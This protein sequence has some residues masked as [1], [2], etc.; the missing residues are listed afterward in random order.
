MNRTAT[1]TRHLASN[2]TAAEPNPTSLFL[3]FDHLTFFV[4]NAKQVAKYYSQAFGFEEVAYKGLETG[5][6]STASHVVKRDNIA[7]CFVSAYHPDSVELGQ[8]VGEHVLKHG[9]GV[10]DVALR[11]TDCRA[12]FYDAVG[13]GAKV[14]RE[15][16]EL[17]DEQGIVVLATIQTYGETVHT[18]VERSRYSGVFLPGY[19][20]VMPTTSLSTSTFPDIR[21][22]DHVVGNQGPHEM[23]AIADWYKDKLKFHRFWTVDDKMIHTEY[24]SLRSIVM[25]DD[26]FSVKMP[27]NEPAEGRKKSQI[28]EFVDFYHGQGVQHVA[29]N[30]PDCIE[31]VIRLKARGV[32]FLTVPSSYYGIFF[33]FLFL[34][35]NVIQGK[36]I[37]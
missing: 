15:P 32:E 23:Q 3:G 14:V 25:A 12:V 5:C 11:V 33:L 19:V 16:F 34:L 35:L 27:I 18:F 17:S 1:V 21:F 22:I 10:K 28:Q 31:T 8:N 24:S 37:F 2:N 4:S 29:L 26:S 9:D 30:T 36:T 7:F 20:S 6:R 13:R